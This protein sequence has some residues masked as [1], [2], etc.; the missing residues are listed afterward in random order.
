MPSVGQLLA[1]AVAGSVETVRTLIKAGQSNIEE[2]NAVSDGA[3]EGVAAFL[4]CVCVWCC[5]CHR[6]GS[7]VVNDE[8]MRA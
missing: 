7:E 5:F 2:R 6:Q 4:L 1:A 3:G 8:W